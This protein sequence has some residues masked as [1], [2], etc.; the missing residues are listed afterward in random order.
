M[1]IRPS[2]VPITDVIS[3]CVEI[4]RSVA[5]ILIS[6]PPVLK[7]GIE[8]MPIRTRD[9]GVH[10]TRRCVISSMKRDLLGLTS[11]TC[12]MMDGCSSKEASS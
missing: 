5:Y 8:A 4:E 7:L 2:D 11:A 3:T 10:I 1:N 12:V 6:R 9:I